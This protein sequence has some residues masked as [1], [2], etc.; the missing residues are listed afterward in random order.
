MYVCSALSYVQ[1][2]ASPW[3]VTHQA[4]LSMEFSRQKYQSG[5]QFPPSADFPNPGIQSMSLA[6]P[7]LTGRFFPLRHLESPCC[8]KFWYQGELSLKVFIVALIAL[9]FSHKN[10]EL[11]S[12]TLPGLSQDSPSCQDQHAFWMLLVCKAK[13]FGIY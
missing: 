3:F 2:F 7:A 1:L 6:S 9:K 12:F 13:A 10:P 8:F 5:L 11:C 4:P